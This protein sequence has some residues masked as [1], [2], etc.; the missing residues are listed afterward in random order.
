MPV[1]FY[2]FVLQ[3]LAGHMVDPTGSLYL[4]YREQPVMHGPSP[5]SLYYE[6][7]MQSG[8][9]TCTS[10]P[11]DYCPERSAILQIES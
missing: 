3:I 5:C 8:L 7:H 11:D 1:S 9:E 6:V 4:L 2:E 10:T